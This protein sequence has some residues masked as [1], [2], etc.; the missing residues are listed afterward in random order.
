MGVAADAL[1][2]L[3]P[4]IPPGEALSYA[5]AAARMTRTA[6]RWDRVVP[7]ALAAGDLPSATDAARRASDLDPDS[8]V[9]ARRWATLATMMLDREGVGVARQ[10][11]QLPVSDSDAGWPPSLEARLALD[12]AGLL[13]LL[14]FAEPEVSAEPRLLAIRAELRIAAGLMDD[15]AR[16]GLVLATRH[17][18]LDGAALAFAATAGRQFST[19]AVSALDAAA[20]TAPTAMMTRMEYRLVA[21]T[22]DPLVDARRLGDEPRARA[23]I[24][25]AH[26][27]LLA[28][29][30]VEGW[31]RDVPSPD[32]HAPEGY[33][34]NPALSTIAGVVGF[35]NPDAATAVLRVGTATGRVPPPIALLYTGRSL[36]VDAAEGGEV[37]RLDGGM[38]PLYAAHAVDADKQEIWGLGFTPEGAKGALTAGMGR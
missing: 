34:I 26:Q 16:D 17:G 2:A 32:P 12:E 27:P 29:A 38:M 25:A 8:V 3:G 15:A 19:L 30:S 35:S 24:Q 1:A 14:V 7:V 28:A 18:R 5:L 13:A 37:L 20:L 21:G 9:R 31:P 11:G 10:R 23:L 6:D 33:R 22:G 36:P 4:S